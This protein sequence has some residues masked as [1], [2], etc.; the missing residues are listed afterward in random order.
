MAR[1]DLTIE[2][3]ERMGKEEPG[4]AARYLE[5]RR[6]ELE[7]EK[8]AEREAADRAE[9]VTT[10][11]AEGGSPTDAADEWTRYRNEK[12]AAAARTADTAALE[13]SRRHVAGRL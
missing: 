2:D 7:C 6:E 13:Q 3:V 10:F 4:S 1:P 5:E 11:V 12:A 8:R 9:F